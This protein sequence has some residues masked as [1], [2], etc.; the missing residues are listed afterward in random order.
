MWILRE[1]GDK[2]G[3]WDEGCYAWEVRVEKGRQG[4]GGGFEGADVCGREEQCASEGAI[5]QGC[6]CTT[7]K[8]MK[9]GWYCAWYSDEHEFF[10]R[11][12]V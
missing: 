9:R 5:L 11:P 2:S 6:Q 7:T 1:G 10:S 3:R 8:G 4:V 12:D